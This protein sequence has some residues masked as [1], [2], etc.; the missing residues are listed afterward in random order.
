MPS[1]LVRSQVASLVAGSPF[2]T[3]PNAGLALQNATQCRCPLR[4]SDEPDTDGIGTD[5]DDGERSLRSDS[6]NLPR[7]LCSGGA[8]RDEK[9][10]PDEECTTPLYS[11]T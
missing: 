11:I 10:A 2:C 5:E 6:R 1:S 3:W 4:G 8:R 7:L 9:N